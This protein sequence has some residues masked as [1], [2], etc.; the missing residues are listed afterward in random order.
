MRATPANLQVETRGFIPPCW[1]PSLKV[2]PTSEALQRSS[3]KTSNA[4]Q[5]GDVKPIQNQETVDIHLQPCCNISSSTCA[6]NWCAVLQAYQAFET[7]SPPRSSPL[8]HPYPAARDITPLH[9]ATQIPPQHSAHP[10]PHQIPEA[11]QERG[12]TCQLLQITSPT[13]VARDECR[14]STPLPQQTRHTDVQAR[15]PSIHPNTRCR[16]PQ[17]AT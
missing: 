5:V 8:F 1:I 12:A 6:V 2:G 3:S 13:R 9:E 4:N 17:A 14:D 7:D 16:H 10:F 11:Q 15:K